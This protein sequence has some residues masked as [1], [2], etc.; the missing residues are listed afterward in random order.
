VSSETI[1]RQQAAI[2]IAENVEFHERTKN[3]KDNCYIVRKKLEANIIVAE[4][5]ESEHQLTDLLTK[6][7]GRTRVYFICNKL[8]V[9]RE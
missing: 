9:L 5:V 3:I 1:R 7:L 8:G 2:H 6:P 4:H